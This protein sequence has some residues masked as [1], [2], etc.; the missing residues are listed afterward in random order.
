MY[1]GFG[2][3][4]L[5]G[6][7]TAVT[8]YFPLGIPTIQ[9]YDDGD[10]MVITFGSV[11]SYSVGNLSLATISNNVI[12]TGGVAGYTVSSGRGNILVGTIQPVQSND[13]LG[14]VNGSAF[15]GNGTPGTGNTFQ[16]TASIGFYAT[17][18]NLLYGLGGNIGF[19]TSK[20][21]QAGTVTQAVG[22]ENDQ[23]VKHF[24]NLIT[25]NVYV[26]THANSGGAT[27]QISFDSSHIYVCLGPNNW[28]RANIA[29]GW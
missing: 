24:G 6:N 11:N 14:Y 9:S 29:G 4:S 23:S 13:I 1:I 18:A 3:G 28:M 7:S 2:G 12:D 22:V 8:G 17:G 27:G 10:D 5:N 16:Q 19:F 21:G 25:S 26:P 20:D 15:T